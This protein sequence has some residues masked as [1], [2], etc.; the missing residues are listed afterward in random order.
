MKNKKK[1]FTLVELIVVLAIL[2][3]LAAMLVPALTGY[4]DKANEKKVVAAA[5][6]YEIAAQTVVSDAYA[7]NDAITNIAVDESGNV[8]I[9]GV[10]DENKIKKYAEDFKSLAELKAKDTC[11]FTFVKSKV[12]DESWTI[13]GNY[14]ATIKSG[15]WVASKS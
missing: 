13:S 7:A 11:S 12:Q 6:Q 3:I 15:A 10:T 4:I 14:K 9:T 8:T 1:G 2:A 5:R